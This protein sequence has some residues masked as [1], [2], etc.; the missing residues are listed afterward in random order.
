[1]AVARS[2][3]LYATS[4]AVHFGVALSLGRMKN[5]KPH[6]AIA[7]ALAETQKEEPPKAEALPPPPPP[8]KEAPPP[9]QKAKIAP[10]PEQEAKP[11][12]TPVEQNQAALDAL[13]DFGLALG[14]GSDVGGIAIPVKSTV[15][16]AAP[17]ATAVQEKVVK[18]AQ[19][20]A[21]VRPTESVCDEPPAKPRARNVPQPSYTSQARAANIE[22]KVRVEITVDEQGQVTKV[23]LLQGLGYGLDEAALEAARHAT[24]EP[25]TR[26]G[27]PSSATFVI[28]MRFSL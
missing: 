3:L 9:Q 28:G 13:P 26:C 1:M 27:K 6:E 12:A 25:G 8:P 17:T 18:K 22:G 5:E 7:I 21:A 20:L 24:F 23:R 19:V 11:A 14:G 10:E 4:I 15:G 2:T 16:A